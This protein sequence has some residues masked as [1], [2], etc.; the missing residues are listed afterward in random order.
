MDG[1]KQNQTYQEQ[2][3]KTEG[4][5][6][7]RGEKT[8]G[9]QPDRTRIL[10]SLGK[11]YTSLYDIDLSTGLFT[12]LSSADDVRA[13]IGATGRAQDRLDY[14]CRHM[15]LPE[16]MEEMLRFVDLSTLDERMGRGRVISKQY[17]SALLSNQEGKNTVIWRQCSFI[18]GERDP[19]GRLTRVIFT[20]Q[21]INEERA[22]ELVDQK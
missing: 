16:Y 8:N 7:E 21:S 14:F 9:T 17:Q 6:R 18:E 4:M 2:T 5:P 10:E 15:I 13:H 12:E 1:R 22:V 3:G 11:I 20:N 19:S